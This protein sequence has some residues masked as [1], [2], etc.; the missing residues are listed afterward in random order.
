MKR[1]SCL[2]VICLSTL[3]CSQS[4]ALCI[5]YNN[6]SS[7]TLRLKTVATMYRKTTGKSLIPQNT[8][9][10][11]AGRSIIIDYEPQ[12]IH[13]VYWKRPDLIDSIALT[14]SISPD[15]STNYTAVSNNAHIFRL[16]PQQ[17]AKDSY[18]IDI[19]ETLLPSSSAKTALATQ[20]LDW[21]TA[22]IRF[23]RTFSEP[24]HNAR[25]VLSANNIPMLTLEKTV[26]DAHTLQ[27]SDTSQFRFMQ[28]VAL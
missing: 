6:H 17:P 13:R 19:T 1:V 7:C 21:P 26:S 5:H 4:F 3:L 8:V 22:V 15:A 11:P 28:R 14:L 16:T 25:I 24:S 23:M 20:C 2:L 10:L 9:L 12:E 18:Y 27:R